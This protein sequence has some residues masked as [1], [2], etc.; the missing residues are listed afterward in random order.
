MEVVQARWGVTY[1]CRGCGCIIELDPCSVTS[2]DFN[3][4][5][6]YFG[7]RRGYILVVL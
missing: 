4:L 1:H 5:V 7:E 2:C 6:V 3:A